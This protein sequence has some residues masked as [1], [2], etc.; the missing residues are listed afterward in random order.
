MVKF[1]NIIPYH[2]NVGQ[3]TGQVCLGLLNKWDADSRIRTLLHAISGALVE[4]QLDSY[5]D[6]EVHYNFTHNKRLYEEKARKSVRK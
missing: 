4:P 5:V 1:I 2:L 6:D 3:S